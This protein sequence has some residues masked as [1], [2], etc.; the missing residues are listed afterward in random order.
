MIPKTT[1]ILE[2]VLIPELRQKRNQGGEKGHPKWQP[3]HA[4]PPNHSSDPSAANRICHLSSAPPLDPRFPS[5]DLSL[6]IHSQERRRR[7][8]QAHHGVVLL[9]KSARGDNR[10]SSMTGFVDE[11]IQ[12]HVFAVSMCCRENGGLERRRAE[13]H[14]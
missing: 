14:P 10:S 11:R 8:I 12:T 2:P 5:A 3:L 4:S 1:P 9:E 6:V 7:A 13:V